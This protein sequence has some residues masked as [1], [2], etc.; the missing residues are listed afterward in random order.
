MNA[1]RIIAYT[2]GILTLLLAVFSF[3][4]SFNALTDLAAQ[5]GVSIPILFPLTVEAAVVIFSLNALYRSLHGESARMQWGL[6]IGASLLAGAFNILHAEPDPLSRTMAAMPSLFLLLSFETFLGQIKHAV[7]RSSV[8]Q[9]IADLNV[10]LEQERSTLN[11]TLEKMHSKLRQRFDQERSEL[12]AQLEQAQA[13]LTGRRS[14]LEQL[15]QELDQLRSSRVELIDQIEELKRSK[16]AAEIVQHDVLNVVNAEKLNDKQQALN[17]LLNF[18]RSNPRATL[19]EA[20]EA[21]DRSKGTVSNYLNELEQAGLIH[22]N[23]NGVEV[24]EQ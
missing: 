17:A 11:G 16:R 4:L 5:H 23:G 6:I 21:I 1:N 20:G 18:Y 24:L 15:E 12:T 10:Q 22:R 9:S 8:V 2:T 19:N 13:D 3:V 14:N 7:T